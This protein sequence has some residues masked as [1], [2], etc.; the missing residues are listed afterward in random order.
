MSDRINSRK[1]CASQYDLDHIYS[2]MLSHCRKVWHGMSAVMSMSGS[3]PH[4][5][6]LLIDIIFR[7]TRLEQELQKV[8]EKMGEIEDPEIIKVSII[9][10]GVCC[11]SFF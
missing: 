5:P 3:P 2:S 9:I 10:S 8:A 4:P 1:K 7:I 11:W 6:L